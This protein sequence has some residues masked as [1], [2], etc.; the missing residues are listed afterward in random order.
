MAMIRAVVRLTLEC[1]NRCVFCAQD[2]LDRSSAV[3]V[4]AA[5]RIARRACDA[6]TFVGG[7]P[8]LDEHL[9]DHVVR[10]RALGFGRIG[11]QTNGGRMAVLVEELARAGLTDLHLSIHGAD[12][13]SHDYHTGIAGSFDRALATLAAARA[14][15]LDV[16]VATV[17][18]R[19]SFRGIAE[20]AQLLAGR[21]VDA[22]L[23]EIARTAGRAADLRDRVVPRL[24]LAMPFALHALDV[25]ARAGMPAWIRGAPLCLLGPFARRAIADTSRAFGEECATCEARPS[26][27][28]VDAEYL[29]RFE[30][31]ELVR[32]APIEADD[33][34]A[35]LRA[36]F[37]GVGELA[38]RATAPVRS[39]VELPM[40]GKV[41][42]AVAEVSSRGAKR[43]GEAL[44]EIL[45]ALFEP[46]KP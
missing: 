13:A 33:D 9:L 44:R 35:A 22:W 23:I 14:A 3:D 24:A 31:D 29:A 26:C 30:G 20:V 45:P 11:V 17:L 32:R 36:M 28:G 6:V 10:A 1:D 37:V 4:E 41:K 34:H 42:P 12:A 40:L 7:E 5:L 16:V 38:R 25:A 19:S 46:K 21:G 39:R 43:S 18:T 27:P 2:G 8:A 15:R